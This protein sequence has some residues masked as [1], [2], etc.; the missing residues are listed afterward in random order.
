MC[1]QHQQYSPC[2]GLLLYYETG[3]EP[4]PPEEIY[5]TV[6]FYTKDDKIIQ[7][8]SGGTLTSSSSNILNSD[9][10]IEYKK[11][12]L[13]GTNYISYDDKL[14]DRNYI[15]KV[16]CR[17]KTPEDEIPKNYT[18][19]VYLDKWK[20][21]PDKVI[22]NR[23]KEKPSEVDFSKS[24]QKVLEEVEAE[25]KEYKIS[26]K[27]RND[28]I[29]EIKVLLL[30][31]SSPI[32]LPNI[33]GKYTVN[34]YHSDT[35]NKI[36]EISGSTV[37][38]YAR[39]VLNS[40]EYKA[41]LKEKVEGKYTAI[42]Q[43]VDPYEKII[44]VWCRNRNPVS[45]LTNYTVKV[46]LNNWDNQV[47]S[48]ADK[49]K[50]T[51]DNVGT[52]Q[53]LQRVID[54]D[55]LAVYTNYALSEM[56][57]DDENAEIRVLLTRMSTNYTIKYYYDY[58]EKTKETETCSGIV[59][60]IITKDTI[61]QKIIAHQ[62]AGYTLVQDPKSILLVMDSSA[63]I[64]RVYYV[65]GTQP[66]LTGFRIEY[67][68]NYTDKEEEMYPGKIGQTITKDTIQQQINAHK[69]EGYILVKDPVAITLGKDPDT[70]IIRVYYVKSEDSKLTGFRIEYYYDYQIDNNA[71]EI[72]PGTIG[73]TITK[74]NVEELIRIHKRE[75]YMLSTK[76]NPN[77]DPL[78]IKLEA[79]PDTNIMRVYY[80]KESKT[81]PEKPE[82]PKLAGYKIQY[83][84]DGKFNNS[85]TGVFSGEEGNTITKEMIQTHIDAHR[86]GYK[87]SKTENLPL[88]LK[89]NIA[90]N[91]IKVYYIKDGSTNP[92]PGGTDPDPGKPDPT[93]NP[94]GTNPGS[95][96]QGGSSNGNGNGSNG[97]GASS[98]TGTSSKG[99]GKTITGSPSD[100]LA[101]KIIPKTGLE[102]GLLVGII[103]LSGVAV[104]CYKKSKWN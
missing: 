84:Y 83:Y 49:V 36:E 92:D 75:G 38:G 78:A 30:K 4:I 52:S 5:Y 100:S 44:T 31:P 90:D 17:E 74:D 91:V 46:F 102:V 81:D 76:D 88:T 61:Q 63:N 32:P 69:K 18:V 64:M 27:P 56:E 1:A 73:Q 35:G 10:F 85:A 94:G 33:W 82:N 97:G 53:S 80:V 19:K 3:I 40:S 60:D 21:S 47:K 39:T 20:D 95:N 34:F 45:D 51:P 50:E 87:F 104:V 67:Y 77:P 11:T 79:D 71:T 54:N 59:G 96:N 9:D 57:Q 24:L 41:L 65:K 101:S 15:I 99:N 55:I 62:K 98:S 42:K 68:Y 43:Q 6:N 7:N 14:D 13:K 72:F 48:I 37:E 2:S 58:D 22:S 25:Y 70:N 103:A 86:N 12:K 93:P 8:I 29:A 16:W 28:E 89:A 66:E 23:I 26:E